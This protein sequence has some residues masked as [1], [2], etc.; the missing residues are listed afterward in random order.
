[1]DASALDPSSTRRVRQP[2]TKYWLLLGIALLVL[3]ALV[4]PPLMNLSH[5]QHRIASSISRSLDR[6]V[7]M[8]SVKLRLLPEPGL[9]ISNFVIEEDPAFGAEPTLRAPSMVAYL[10]LASLWRGRL[11][12][13]RISLDEPSLNLVRNAQGRWNIGA[14]LVQ[15]SRLPNAPTAQRRAGP[16][17]RFPY[18]EAND[19]RINFKESSEKKPFSLLNADFSMWLASP[20]EWQ[21]RVEAQPV[22]TD[23]DLDLAETGTLRISGTLRRSSAESEASVLDQMP[24]ELHAD[25]SNAPLGQISRLLLGRN[26]GWRGSLRIHADVIG[27]LE[28]LRLKTRLRIEDMH[29]QEFTP[30]ELLNIEANCQ[31]DYLR[32]SHSLNNV[33]CVWP[34]GDGQFSL[35]GS[36]QNLGHPQLDLTLTMD[37]LP[38][39]LALTALRMVRLGAAPSVGVSGT[40]DGHF[41]YHAE[42]SQPL[43]GEATVHALQLTAPGLDTPLTVSVMHFITAA[44]PHN[45]QL[46]PAQPPRRSITGRTRRPH[47]RAVAIAG[48]AAVTLE[49]FPLAMS[50]QPTQSAP[51]ML[52]GQF[53]AT[54]FTLHIGGQTQ[55]GNLLTLGN[56]SGWL[57]PFIAAL[58]PQGTADLDV[59][60]HGPW[61]LSTMPSPPADE[62][63]SV[64]PPVLAGTPSSVITEGTLRLRNAVYRPRFLAEPVEI[65]SAQA[66][67][68]PVQVAW[69]PVAAVYHHIPV[70]LSVSY[71][72]VCEVPAG[73][74]THFNANMDSLNAAA[75]ESALLGA[76]E[77]GELLDQILARFDGQSVRWPALAGTVHADI[78]TL[79]PLALHDAMASVAIEGRLL[80]VIALDGQ[81]LGGTFHVTGSINATPDP[82]A[83]SLNMQLA[84]GNA[85]EL[86]TLFKEEWGAGTVSANWRLE[87]AGYSAAQLASSAHGVFH[88][89]WSR[90]T[91]PIAQSSPLDH[92]DRWSADGAFRDRKIHL[93]RSVLVHGA[94]SVP[95]SGTIGFD[96]SLD[97]KLGA[98]DTVTGTLPHP[99]AS[100]PKE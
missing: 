49:D 73:C 27:S 99:V 5:Y 92:F 57:H 69:N 41:T 15:A 38:V 47:P 4:L 51:L 43:S 61:L 65:V 64:Q 78:L 28:S 83:Y 12:V 58:Q 42:S 46:H 20:G 48:P 70:Q 40:V 68:S 93:D 26:T 16:A 75:L 19:G 32:G 53:T 76:G 1:M 14:V 30:P 66:S 10:R 18:I 77:H 17:P 82:A 91:L 86:A 62:D 60:I 80:R 100:T 22:R 36:V 39:S 31:G 8:S 45:Q 21:L 90:G 96:R 24:V 44:V 84:H 50:P 59:T 54:G 55:I 13:S 98:E 3:A 63:A 95:V 74:L 2:K 88:A 52:G 9:E 71:P 7:E 35:A 23:L 37:K 85:A 87:M 11:E 29:R 33:A 67:L 97:L 72:L 6:P 79:G 81:A 34:I 94:E 25:W 56:D 89:D